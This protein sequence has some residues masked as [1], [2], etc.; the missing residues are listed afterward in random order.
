MVMQITDMW[1]TMKW[2][3]EKDQPE[4]YGNVAIMK[5]VI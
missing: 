3:Y 2:Q 4:K 1:K 5:V